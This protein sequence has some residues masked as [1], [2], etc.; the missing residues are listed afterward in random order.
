MARYLV[1]ELSEDEAL[2]NDLRHYTLGSTELLPRYFGDLAPVNILL[3]E[4]NSGKSRLMRE[5]M[6]RNPTRIFAIDSTVEMLVDATNA[7]IRTIDHATMDS[8]FDLEIV[9]QPIAYR[10]DDLLDLLSIKKDNLVTTSSNKLHVKLEERVSQIRR[11][12]IEIREQSLSDS[13]LL[14]YLT[15]KQISEHVEELNSCLLSLRRAAKIYT[16]FKSK[17]IKGLAFTTYDYVRASYT[18]TGASINILAGH[19]SSRFQDSAWRTCISEEVP[20]NISAIEEAAKPIWETLMLFRGIEAKS[21]PRVYIPTLRTAR[22]LVSHEGKKIPGEHDMLQ[23]TTQADYQLDKGADGVVVTTGMSLYNAVQAKKNSGREDRAEFLE[24]ELFLSETF[25]NGKKVEVVPKQSDT[26]ILID[27]DGEE[28][29]LPHLGDGIQ[30]IIMLLYPLFIAKKGTWFFIEE[31]ETH[32]HPGF[33]RLFIDTIATHKVL[34]KKELT[35]FLT[36]HS[37]HLLDFALNETNRVNLFTFRKAVGKSGKPE[38]Q[39]QLTKPQDLEC[40]SALGVR[41]SSVFLSN[42]TIWVE[43]ITDRIYLKAYLQVYLEHRQH[44]FSLLDGLHY[45]FLEYAG[46]NVSHYTFGAKVQQVSITDQA[47]KEIQALSISNRIMLIADKDAGK[48]AKHEHLTSQQ[49]AG[50]EYIMLATREIE[51]LLSPEIIASALKKLW[52]KQD[53]DASKLQ[54]EQYRDIYLGHYL[55]KKYPDIP[56]G[57]APPKPKGSGTIGSDYKRRFAEAAAEVITSWNMLSPEAQTLT[58]RVFD[59]II[60]HNPRLGNN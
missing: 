9:T 31:P 11:I 56:E 44:A 34:R 39:V 17:R 15:G 59:F 16:E 28:R 1:L 25:F 33:Q 21:R 24:F 37:N 6:R 48:D 2:Q 7:V 19:N 4:N 5:L 36:T 12:A 38:F 3:G 18:G 35:I 20:A 41:N 40:L 57:F 60:G 8:F 55:R 50:F 43:G 52:H 54:Q 27:V 45:S 10:D 42:C 32:L 30:A 47:L 22:T 23:A 58:K 46:A 26:S 49:H 13:L 29:A 51:N 53:F 14:H